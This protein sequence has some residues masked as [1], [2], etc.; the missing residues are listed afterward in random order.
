MSALAFNTTPT[1]RLGRRA[2]TSAIGCATLVLQFVNAQPAS[3]VFRVGMLWLTDPNLPSGQKFTELTK[4]GLVEGVNVV[5][6]SRAAAGSASRLDAAAAELVALKPD[7]IVVVS[8]TA[9]AFAARRATTTIPI[10]FYLVNDP[11]SSGLVQSL[12]RPGGNLTGNAIF[13]KQ[14]DLKRFQLLTEVVGSTADIAV[15]DMSFGEPFKSEFLRLRPVPMA[16][17]TFRTE[18]FEVKEATEFDAAFERISHEGFN[19]VAINQFPLAS[20]H[21]AR[22]ADLTA[23]YRLPAVADGRNF[24]EAG[25]LLTYTTDTS[26]LWPRTAQYVRKIL[27]GARP[28]DLAVELVSRYEFIINLRTARNL[29]IKVP[30]SVLARVSRSIE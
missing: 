19:A 24:A 25:V 6:D 8:G 28:A 11:V 29:G 3:K 14:L 17:R 22:I 10:V 15:I 4:L 13:S 5:I 1:P 27:S 12:A 7:V 2:F 18:F 21:E 23:R 9:G 30:Q 16:G 20:I 26:E